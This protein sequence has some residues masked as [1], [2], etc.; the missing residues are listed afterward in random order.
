M[1]HNKLRTY[2]RLKGF[3]GVEEYLVCVRN[4]SQRADLSRLRV[5]AHSLGVER[6]RYTRP[7]IPLAQRG[8]RFCGPPGPRVPIGSSGRGPVDDEQHAMTVCS[9]LVAERA[10]LYREMSNINPSFQSLTCQ[11]K[12]VRLM[13][14][15]NPIECKLISI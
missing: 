5:S 12:F 6:L 14:P 8:C 15:V 9:L 3:F 1:N 11:D 4:R 2:S 13:C 10:E 7:A